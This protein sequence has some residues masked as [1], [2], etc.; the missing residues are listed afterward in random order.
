MATFRYVI[1]NGDAVLSSL[2]LITAAH[3]HIP[4]TTRFTVTLLNE[5]KQKE[6]V[7]KQFVTGLSVF[8]VV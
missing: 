3:C 8:E 2:Q 7:Q 1:N 4:T 6:N 5:L